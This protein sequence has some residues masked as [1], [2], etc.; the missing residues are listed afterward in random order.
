MDVNAVVAELAEALQGIVGLRVF[1]YVPGT[2]NP[3][4]VIIPPPPSVTFD[5][6]FG[7]G[8]DTLT[9]EMYVIAA[10]DPDRSGTA[11]LNGFLS[12]SGDT[13]IKAAIEGA[14]YSEFDSV[15]VVSAEAGP[16]TIGGI[17]YLG[18]MFT[19]DIIGSGS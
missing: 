11:V 17:D 13:S 16:M 3:P 14:T 8:A 6:T 15:R 2:V 18:A 9:F 12:G 7:R 4:A 5:D 19:L 10:P 1:G